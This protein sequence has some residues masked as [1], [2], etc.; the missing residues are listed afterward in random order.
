M[1]LSQVL[2]VPGLG[3]ANLPSDKRQRAVCLYQSPGSMPSPSTRA[4]FKYNHIQGMHL[5]L[6]T[7]LLRAG[8]RCNMATAIRMRFYRM[9]CP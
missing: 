5:S 9:R 2:A 1:Q 3:Q 7:I 6:C 4:T 8:T